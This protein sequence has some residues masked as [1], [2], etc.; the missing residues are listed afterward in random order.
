MIV[1]FEYG[2]FSTVRGREKGSHSLNNARN[3]AC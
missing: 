3:P 1:V 2:G